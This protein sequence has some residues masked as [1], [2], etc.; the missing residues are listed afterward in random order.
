M[1]LLAVAAGVVLLCGASAPTPLLLREQA[2]TAPG[3]TLA[4]DL[5]HAPTECLA[6]R[7]NES[8]IGRALFRTPVMLGGPAARAGLSCN[9]CHSNGGVNTRFM[10][11]ELTDRPGHSDVTSE[12]AS[13]TRGDGVANPLPIPDLA[14]SAGHATFGHAREPSLDAFVRG[15]IVDEFQGEAPSEQAFAG[16]MAYIRALRLRACPAAAVAP[17]TLA[18]ASD[19]VRRAL[20][21]AEGADAETAS[22]LLLAAQ[23]SIGRIVERLPEPSFSADRRR[24]EALARELGAM[25][26]GE[27]HAALA[28]GA[29]GWR[30]RF[31][32][33]VTRI[34]RGETRTYFNEQ[35][36]AQALAG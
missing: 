23:D 10:L 13:A 5:T 4:H 17:V 24:F 30:A 12:W 28:A 2:W 18:T 22:L 11:P 31:D 26:G 32:A 3:P 6:S 8:E 1:R 21:A 16:M 36:L 14:G 29:Q 33:A 7:T 20:G 15:V 27:V 35:T 34:A 25:R 9:A 19:D